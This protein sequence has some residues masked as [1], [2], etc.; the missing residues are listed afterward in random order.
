MVVVTTTP[1]RAGTEQEVKK[2]ERQEHVKDGSTSINQPLC[3]LGLLIQRDMFP[4]SSK[5]PQNEVRKINGARQDQQEKL[6][7]HDKNERGA[8]GTHQGRKH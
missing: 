4:V 2:E 5:Y 7:A 3:T 1:T 8:A 6:P